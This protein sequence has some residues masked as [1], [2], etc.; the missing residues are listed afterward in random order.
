M[1]TSESLKFCLLKNIIQVDSAQYSSTGGHVFPNMVR[2]H[3]LVYK[4]ALNSFES[5]PLWPFG[6]DQV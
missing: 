1:A 5:L 3:E 6:L 4:P 2:A